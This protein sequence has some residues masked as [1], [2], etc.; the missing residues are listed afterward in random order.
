MKL[1]LTALATVATALAVPATASA[2]ALTVDPA[3]PC[4]G[5]GH[6]VNLLGS[7]FSPGLMSG[8]SV[9]KDGEAIGTLSTD[10]TGAF[11]GQLRLGQKNGRRTSVY[12][13][14]DTSNPT[15]TASTQ[16][17]VSEAD[18]GLT[19][20]SGAPGRK[21]KIKAVGFTAGNGNLYAHITRGDST[22]N[23][24]IGELGGA[25]KKITKR[26]RLLARDA[27]AGVYVVQFDGYRKYQ[28]RRPQSVGFTITVREV[29]KSG[30]A[31]ASA[32]GWSRIF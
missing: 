13:A 27:K 30:A 21:V 19:P 11:N 24:R 25:C 14:T 15:L 5:S 3:L 29:V 12:T 26:R 31:A 23:L 16:I 32:A 1:R 7:G 9:T 8:I 10:A 6:S 22:R 20:K 4:Y 28:E 18:V 2:A 17:V